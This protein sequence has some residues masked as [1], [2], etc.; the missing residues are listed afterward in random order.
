MAIRNI[1]I[2]PNAQIDPTKIL[3]GAG[4]AS[5]FGKT[6]YV[7]S[8]ATNAADKPG[9]GKSPKFPFATLGYAYSS[10][11]VQE[12]RGDR[13][14][15]A[16]RHAETIASVTGCVLDRDGIE[17]IG[18]GHGTKRPTFT[19]TTL[20]TATIV[21]SGDNN[22]LSNL[23][24]VAGKQSGD[25]IVALIIVTGAGNQIVGCEF[26]DG[27][28]TNQALTYLLISTGAND[29]KVIGNHFRLTP[30]DTG[31]AQAISISSVV[32][33]T[34]IQNNV[35]HGDFSNAAINSTVAHLECLIEWNDL[36]N[37][38]SE[39]HCIQFS[40]A[41]TGTIRFNTCYCNGTLADTMPI[42]KGSCGAYENYCC[43]TDADK[44]G[45][46]KPAGT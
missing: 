39:D 32:S 43:D 1:N 23:R 22:K 21:L 13:I 10:D 24:F 30:T 3:G 7:D 18:L 28:A 20:T 29:T 40:A 37:A 35:I 2:D 26:R 8:E 27:G 33:R 44:S 42:D 38:Q 45:V 41:A 36:W 11:L 5:I 4:L 46:L 19:I 14:I 31:C 34:D 15:V 16:A 9:H 6:W 12:D 17:V 25:D